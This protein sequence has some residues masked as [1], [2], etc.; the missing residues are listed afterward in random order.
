[1]ILVAIA[2]DRQALVALPLDNHVDAIPAGADLRCNA[3]TKLK[4][5]FENFSF[6]VR[7][8]KSHQIAARAD[9]AFN[10]LTH[11]SDD[12]R[13]KVLRIEF[14]LANGSNEI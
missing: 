7:I 5:P 8:A 11:M 10:W 4:K 13:L 9:A 12:I 1:M 6:E 2:F 14:F 3:I